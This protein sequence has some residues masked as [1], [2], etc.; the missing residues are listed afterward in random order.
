VTVGT[1][2][3]ALL[4]FALLTLPA[5]AALLLT[6][7]VRAAFSSRAALGVVLAFGGL[8]TSFCFDL[9]AGPATVALLSASVPVAAVV[10][11]RR[12]A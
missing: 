11:R 8:A 7:R 5:T 12:R 4:T 6:A 1:H 2:L 10:S 3:G 9:P